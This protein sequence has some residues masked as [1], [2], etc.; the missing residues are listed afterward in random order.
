MKFL[1]GGKGAGNQGGLE[2]GM[3]GVEG[4]AKAP[5]SKEDKFP[6]QPFLLPKTRGKQDGPSGQLN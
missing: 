1:R 5:G 6:E 2:E 4:N 3:E